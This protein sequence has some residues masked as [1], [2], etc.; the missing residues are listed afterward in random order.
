MNGES[1]GK[2]V[3]PGSTYRQSSTEG[4]VR[5]KG[6]EGIFKAHRH[7]QK[8]VEIEEPVS[9]CRVTVDWIILSD[10]GR[11]L[12]SGGIRPGL[13]QGYRDKISRLSTGAP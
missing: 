8:R 2:L 11:Y 13:F 10:I 6:R 1:E 5:T 7:D 9:S 4:V 3:Y 12:D